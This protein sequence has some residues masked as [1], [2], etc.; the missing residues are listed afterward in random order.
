MNLLTGKEINYNLVERRPGDPA[1]LIAVSKLAKDIIDWECEYSD[2][3]T[4]I[5]SM[6]EIYTRQ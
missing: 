5:E 6:W 3:T 2:M 4:I 1:E